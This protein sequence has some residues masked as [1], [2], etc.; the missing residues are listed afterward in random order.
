[1]LTKV[2]N[3]CSSGPYSRSTS[4]VTNMCCMFVLILVLVDH[5]L[6]EENYRIMTNEIYVLI[7]VLVD[8]ALGDQR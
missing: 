6:G 1:M 3:P 4:N 5:A 7:L 2:H 8:H